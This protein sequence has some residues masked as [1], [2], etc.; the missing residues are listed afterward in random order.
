MQEGRG[1]EV[2]EAEE[3]EGGPGEEDE[4]LVEGAVEG[5]ELAELGDWVRGIGAAG[6]VGCGLGG[7]VLVGGN[8][9][10]EG[11]AYTWR[12]FAK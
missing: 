1:V 8:G 11:R 6:G 12:E 9:E 5:V 7:R 10:D 3:R 4:G 2:A